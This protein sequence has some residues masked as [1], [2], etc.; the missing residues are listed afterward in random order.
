[1]AHKSLLPKQRC[2][3][4][5]ET[6]QTFEAWRESMIFMISLSDKSSRFLSSG[7]LKSWTTDEDRGFTDDSTGAAGV[8]P[9]NKMNKAAKAALLNIVLGS[10]AGYA[11]VISSKFIKRQST[12]LESIWERLR[13][14]YGF[15]RTGSR[16]LELMEFKLEQNESRESLW[17]ILY[18]FI[19]DQMLTANGSVKHEGVVQTR[20]EKFT[21]TLL[22]I[23]VTTWLHTINPALPSLV[24]QR[25]STQL[26]DETLYSIRDEVSDSI[27]VL[28]E[29]LDAKECS[30]NRAG[31]FQ[32]GRG[33]RNKGYSNSYSGPS[34]S[35]NNYSSPK[36]NC[37]LCESAGRQSTSHFLSTCPYLPSEDRKFM[38]KTREISSHQDD[39][40]QDEDSYDEVLAQS[41]SRQMNMSSYSGNSSD[42]A[43]IRKTDSVP[44]LYCDIRLLHFILS[45]SEL[46]IRELL[47]P[48]HIIFNACDKIFIP[49]F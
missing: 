13:S 46:V 20:N 43:P 19:E 23:L 2:L 24:K 1:M 32:R 31:A 22:N 44:P 9:E 16:I 47:Y 12:S 38:S 34:K 8:T 28:L 27:P 11:P 40:L 18:S 15:R 33:N 48:D 5:Q 25:F 35:Y 41:V 30:I 6:Q 49:S 39:E 14:H 7:N 4:E 10:I 21:P 45:I 36:R 37:C 17:E 26:R 42:A 29:E 3:T